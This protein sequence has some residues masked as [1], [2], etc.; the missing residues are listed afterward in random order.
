MT[1]TGMKKV[2]RFEYKGDRSVVVEI[3]FDEVNDTAK[4]NRFGTVDEA[5]ITNGVFNRKL[6]LL[7]VL[8]GA[9]VAKAIDLRKM[10]VDMYG[11]TDE[12]KMEYLKARV[13]GGAL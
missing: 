3:F 8:A 6:N 11:M 10:A 12:Q 1:I 9:T 5:H 4:E 2:S 7:D 13:A